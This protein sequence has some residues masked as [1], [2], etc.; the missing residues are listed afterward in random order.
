M[1]LI[2]E[3]ELRDIVSKGNNNN[4][5][6]TIQKANYIENTWNNIEKNL[7]DAIKKYASIGKWKFCVKMPNIDTTIVNDNDFI[8]I[9]N[10]YLMENNVSYDVFNH[11]SSE[12]K[13]ITC[14][15]IYGR[16]I[17]RV[18]QNITL[19][20]DHIDNDIDYPT[21]IILCDMSYYDNSK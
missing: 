13:L 4:N 15:I 19:R 17:N 11:Y 12:F 10:N 14:S 20:C 6:R 1:S 5:A 8:D 2:T 21:I 9:L 16:K 18:Y 3:E 7:V